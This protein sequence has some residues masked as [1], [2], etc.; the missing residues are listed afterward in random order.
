MIK[1]FFFALIVGLLVMSSQIVAHADMDVSSVNWDSVQRFSNRADLAS[2]IEEGRRKGQTEFYF[3]LT[4]VVINNKE[5]YDRFFR[6]EFVG[7]YVSAPR[8]DRGV[9]YGTGRLAYRIYREYPGMLVANAYDEYI[10]TKENYKWLELNAE[11]KQLYNIAVGIVAEANKRNSEVEKARYIHD[12]ICRRVHYKNENERNTTALGLIDGYVQC[13]G[14]ADAFYML[15]RMCGLNVRKI[16]GT[17]DRSAHMWNWITFKDGKSYFVD[18]GYRYFLKTKAQMEKNYWCK[19]D[20]V[21][22]LQ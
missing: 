8:I 4:N 15:G 21:P 3:V 6:E 12:E 10:R 13:R 9:V 7:G 22:N 14:Y 2:Y 11:E 16:N 19:W 1:K 17:R 5:E 18:V 20:V